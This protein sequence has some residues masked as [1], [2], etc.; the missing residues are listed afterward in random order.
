MSKSLDSLISDKEAVEFHKN[1]ID[2]M[3]KKRSVKKI[4]SLGLAK[5]K[6]IV[7]GI[8]NNEGE[9]TPEQV[10]EHMIKRT[11]QGLEFIQVVKH[12]MAHKKGINHNDE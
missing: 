10:H 3:K 4:L 7:F 5:N 11:Q 9:F 1:E 8:G 12:E 2:G 6:E